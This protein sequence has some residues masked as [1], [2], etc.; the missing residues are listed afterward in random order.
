MFTIRPPLGLQP[1][2]C[3]CICICIHLQTIIV[4][5]IQSVTEYSRVIQNI[6]E[7]YRVF[8]AHLLGPISGLVFLDLTGLN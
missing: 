1:C 3:I 4:E 8:L 7:H 2:I 6:T 5:V